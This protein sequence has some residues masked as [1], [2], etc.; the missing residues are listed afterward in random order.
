[1]NNKSEEKKK[2]FIPFLSRL[3]GGG[4]SVSSMGSIGSTA[5]KFGS[6][7][8]KGFWASIIG[9]KAGVVGLVLGAATITAGIG[10]IYNYIGPSSS[11]VYTPG[12][13][14]DA[15]YEDVQKQA[16]A[17]RAKEFS[18]NTQRF[19]S[20]L[21]MFKEAAQKEL[22]L[23]NENNEQG[24]SENPS[25][26]AD[27]N[28][29]V[30]TNT[31]QPLPVAEN[32]AGANK[33]N[34]SL[35]F[36]S[37]GGNGGS[38]SS[39]VNRLQTSG[40]LWGGIGRPFSPISRNANIASSGSSSKMNKALTARVVTSPKYT[41]PNVNKKGAFGQAKYAANVGK[42]AVFNAS[43]A[44]ARTTAEQ[45]FS[46]ETAG[47]GDIA[48]PIGGT[49]LG[50]AGLS[51]GSKLK[52]NDPSLNQ[53]EYTPPTPQK[54]DDTPWKK[55]TDYALYAMLASAA[56]IL[57]ASLLANKAKA[58][59]APPA[60]ANLPL[61][62][63]LLN[64]AKIFCYLA[65]AAAAIVIGIGVNLAITYGQKLMGIMY[66]LVGGALIYQAYKALS[67]INEG[68][69]KAKQAASDYDKMLSKMNEG[70]REAF[71]NLAPEK[72]ASHLEAY[73]NDPTTYE[74]GLK[75]L[76]GQ[77]LPADGKTMY[78]IAKQSAPAQQPGTQNVPQQS[79]P[80]QG[81]TPGTPGGTQQGPQ[82]APQGTESGT[83]N[84]PQQ[85]A[86]TQGSTPGT[87][88]GTQQP[89]STPQQGQ[90]PE[91]SSGAQ[92]GPQPAPQKETQPG[93]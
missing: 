3:F 18:P 5:S 20:S 45:A 59:L 17:E 44:G 21:D 74:K 77:K 6:A 55:L 93:R 40:G 87:P 53:S 34:A 57:I 29:D 35:G 56:F 58:L 25:D 41:V 80:T 82:P 14:S 79:T 68:L 13:F 47:S 26:S 90:A 10:V 46:G 66:G 4:G 42:T 73:R 75:N 91:T 16:N 51:Q 38:G 65:I 81:S 88:G 48:T 30:N 89:T 32:Q 49:G 70:Q 28:Q 86:P 54:K 7:A 12:L 22:S 64:A 71:K 8:G 78:E 11:K 83:T 72:Q 36:E 61:A 39:S 19:A 24:K 33:L 84:V 67:G 92:Q 2:G 27:V 62:T 76:N 50:G 69:D 85:S 1:M 15:Y 60:L 43:D 9:S 63:S 37:K 52:A 23:K 31:A